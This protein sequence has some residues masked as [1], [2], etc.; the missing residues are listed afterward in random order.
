MQLEQSTPN[1]LQGQRSLIITC[2]MQRPSMMLAKPKRLPR[3]VLVS[4]ATCIHLLRVSA[5]S[6]SEAH[7]RIVTATSSFRHCVLNTQSSH[8]NPRA[9]GICFICINVCMI[10]SIIFR[11]SFRGKFFLNKSTYYK[12]Y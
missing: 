8:N 9:C 1:R 12:D 4:T 5:L 6:A 2:G 10:F 3:A 11:D 7:V